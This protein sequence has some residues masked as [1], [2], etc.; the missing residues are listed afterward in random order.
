MTKPFKIKL[1]YIKYKISIAFVFLQVC[2]HHVGEYLALEVPGLAE[3]RPSILIGD[4]V[5]L[6]V[7][8]DPEG[9]SYEG[10]VHEVN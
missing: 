8:Y 9:P 3:G 2:L 6:S 7:P 1:Q 5:I 4:K 10:Y